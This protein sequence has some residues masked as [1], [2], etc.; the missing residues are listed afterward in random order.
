MLWMRRR[1]DAWRQ[2]PRL[3]EVEAANAE[4]S[5]ELGELRLR[6]HLIKQFLQSGHVKVRCAA[7][8]N[9]TFRWV[10][11]PGPDRLVPSCDTC[12]RA[13]ERAAAKDRDA[14]A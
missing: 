9:L 2:G 13:R 8:G 10:L 7:C 6:L 5:K 12:E 11:H 4:A 1:W 14:A 3:R